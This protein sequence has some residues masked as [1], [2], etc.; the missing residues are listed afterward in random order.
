M[1]KKGSTKTTLLITPVQ[2]AK[3]RSIRPQMVYNWIT[4]QGGPHE[5]LG[6]KFFVNAAKL[7]EWLDDRKVSRVERQERSKERRARGKFGLPP[8][9]S[10]ALQKFHSQHVQHYCYNCE[11]ETDHLCDLTYTGDPVENFRTSYCLECKGEHTMGPLSNEDALAV[12]LHGA[13]LTVPEPGAE[14]LLP[15]P[16]PTDEEELGN[17]PM[18]EAG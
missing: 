16:E 8:E 10:I 4:R 12:L 17:A 2:Y 15:L 7:D 11:R 6:G 13:V 1:A 3:Q 14:K 5:K 18:E 9:V